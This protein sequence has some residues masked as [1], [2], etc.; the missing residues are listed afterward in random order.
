MTVGELIDK[1]SSLDPA[2]E[3]VILDADTSWYLHI[4][5]VVKYK[6]D[7]VTIR[8]GYGNQYDKEILEN[9]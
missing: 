1:L 3:V 4:E 8:G 9:E 6:T 2:S 5:S 7:P